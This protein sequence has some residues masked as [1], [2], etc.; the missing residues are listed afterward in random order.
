LT[1]KGQ[2]S[3]TLFI[4]SLLVSSLPNFVIHETTA[5][6]IAIYIEQTYGYLILDNNMSMP[7]ALVNFTIEPSLA[8]GAWVSYDITMNA[9]FS[10][11]SPETQLA[12]IGLACPNTWLS[13]I[14]E[15]QILENETLLPHVILHYDE[16]VSE[17]ETQTARWDF[18]DFITFNCSLEAD[19]QTDIVFLMDFES[20]TAENGFTFQYFV[21]TA[22]SWNGTTHEV[23]IMNMKNPSLLQ[24]CSFSPN[25]FV[26]VDN[27][28]P[29][30]TAT[31]D[32]TMDV[33][34]DDYVQFTAIHNQ[35]F[36]PEV[37]PSDLMLVGIAV[38]ITIG[39]LVMVVVVVKRSG[40][41]R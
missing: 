40:I 9:T 14:S 18:L 37:T 28:P 8:G 32:L 3:V 13:N 1:S 36:L 2:I 30:R 27:N 15:I 17:N 35:P 10:F 38:S 41:M 7:E 20:R 6:P 26:T 16:L 21:A 24:S 4:V 23:I 19:K 25:D 39:I 31:W 5:N 34:E 22:H 11:L 12:T 33:F 29:W